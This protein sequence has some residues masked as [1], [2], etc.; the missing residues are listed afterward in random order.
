MRPRLPRCIQ[1]L[2]YIHG[3]DRSPAWMYNPWFGIGPETPVFLFPC[4]LDKSPVN[5]SIYSLWAVSQF[6][7]SDWPFLWVSPPRSLFSPS[8]RSF[9]SLSLHSGWHAKLLLPRPATCDLVTRRFTPA[10]MWRVTLYD[11]HRGD[12]PNGKPTKNDQLTSSVEVGWVGVEW[13]CERRSSF[14]MLF[15]SMC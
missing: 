4:F 6:P 2:L 1:F 12:S 15:L 5:T 7:C 9:A 8:S 3:R 10:W 14:C 13:K 11:L